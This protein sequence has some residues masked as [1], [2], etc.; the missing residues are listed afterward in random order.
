[1][2][3]LGYIRFMQIISWWE[4]P[5]PLRWSLQVIHTV[6]PS[7]LIRIHHSLPL[8]TTSSAHPPRIM[9]RVLPASYTDTP[10]VYG[11]SYISLC[12]RVMVAL[13][14]VKQLPSSATSDFTDWWL[15]FH[16][17]HSQLHYRLAGGL[18]PILVGFFGKNDG[19]LLMNER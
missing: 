11:M 16:C 1:M 9:D 2:E 14:T 15:V 17:F 10:L 19:T 12:L 4:Q 6:V 18:C 8:A 13:F 3:G 7:Y 5:C